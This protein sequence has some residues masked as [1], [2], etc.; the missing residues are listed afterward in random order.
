MYLRYVVSVF[1]EDE[2]IDFAFP[3]PQ[4]FP[5]NGGR[6]VNLI[7]LISGNGRSGV[8]SFGPAFGWDADCVIATPTNRA[9]T[10]I[11]ETTANETGIY[12]GVGLKIMS[13]RFPD[14][15]T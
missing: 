5:I 9:L 15:S 11:R 6:N 8:V 10:A 7:F 4:P 1:N 14:N 2:L 13:G 12:R 3:Q